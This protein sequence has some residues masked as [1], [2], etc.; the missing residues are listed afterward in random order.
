MVVTPV[1]SDEMHVGQGVALTVRETSVS[2]DGRNGF[3]SRRFECAAADAN[4]VVGVL[5]VLP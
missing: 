1:I 5:V 3:L 4:R 2:F